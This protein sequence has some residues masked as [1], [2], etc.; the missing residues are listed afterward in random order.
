MN[1]EQLISEL[2]KSECFSSKLVVAPI[3]SGTINRSFQLQDQGQRYFLKEFEQIDKI[4]VDRQA[5]F[6]V[7]RQVAAIG[8]AP[9]PLY[10]SKGD[11]FQ[12]EQWVEHHSLAQADFSDDKKMALLAASLRNIHQVTVK[13]KTLDLAADWQRYIQSTQRKPLPDLADRLSHCE[14][15]WREVCQRDQVFCHHDLAMNHVSVGQEA[16]IFD[17]EYAAY[18]NRFFDLAAC[19]LVNN[20]SETQSLALQVHYAELSNIPPETV[21]NETIRQFPLIK[22]TNDLWYLA[23]GVEDPAQ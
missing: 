5:Q 15:V 3:P 12:V 6:E 18:G 23:A 17:W 10:L 9:E 8:L 4:P 1:E 13:A 16:V 19:I 21:V 14:K 22:L 2:H 20:L 11:T 7:Q